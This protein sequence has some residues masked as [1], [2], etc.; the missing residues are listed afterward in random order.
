MLFVASITLTNILF[1]HSG[2]LLTHFKVHLVVIIVCLVL[3]KINKT[4]QFYNCKSIRINN[5]LKDKEYCI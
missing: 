1:A 5:L 2:Y 3:R 4:T